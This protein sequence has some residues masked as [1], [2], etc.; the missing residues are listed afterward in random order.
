MNTKKTFQILWRGKVQRE[1]KSV[2]LQRA[3]AMATFI[4]YSDREEYPV[5]E[6]QKEAA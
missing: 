6:K 1:F 2:S 4:G 3:C 5:V